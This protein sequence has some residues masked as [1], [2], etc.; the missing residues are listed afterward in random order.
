VGV[1]R[2]ALNPRHLSPA[3]STSVNP[4]KGGFTLLELLVVIGII[5]TVCALFLPV[6]SGAKK[7]AFMRQSGSN[8]HQL[9][10]AAIMYATDNDDL[11]P[12]D[13]NDEE[14]LLMRDPAVTTMGIPT[15]SKMPGDLV[16]CLGQ[17]LS[18]NKGV[19]FTRADPYLG[20]SIPFG[21]INHHYTSYLYTALPTGF[22]PNGPWPIV[23][24]LSDLLLGGSLFVEPLGSVSGELVS[25]WPA[26]T[27]QA[28]LSDGSVQLGHVERRYVGP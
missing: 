10:L 16:R 2:G 22:N 28:A 23:S 26:G 5:A 12:I 24:N 19:W 15:D 20:T 18:F 3:G 25:Y 27:S 4:S 13:R 11:L 6:V 14:L 17:Y 21:N 1:K 7:S 8:L 9:S